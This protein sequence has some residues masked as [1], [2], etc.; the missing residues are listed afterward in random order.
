MFGLPLQSD[1]RS[2]S[3]KSFMFSDMYNPNLSTEDI[4]TFTFDAFGTTVTTVLSDQT[5]AS[6]F[7]F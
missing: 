3:R 2:F 7:T 6:K 1:W 4:A 5:V